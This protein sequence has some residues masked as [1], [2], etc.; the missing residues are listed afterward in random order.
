MNNATCETKLILMHN[1]VTKNCNIEF[2]AVWR[3]RLRLEESSL[4]ERLLR[5]KSRGRNCSLAALAFAL[6]ETRTN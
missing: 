4:R 5:G 2:E 6:E 3:R 1:Y